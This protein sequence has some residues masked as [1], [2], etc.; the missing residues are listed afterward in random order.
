[1]WTKS[2]DGKT[3][4][5]CGAVTAALP[6]ADH[7]SAGA[8]DAATAAPTRRVRPR[9]RVLSPALVA[10]RPDVPFTAPLLCR[11]PLA[12]A[13]VCPR[14]RRPRPEAGPARRRPVV[15]RAARAPS[16]ARD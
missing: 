10:R 13:G 4:M 9:A 5:K 15:C 6:V 2:R 1:M 7:T 3:L 14:R 8:A 16:E 12:V 11:D